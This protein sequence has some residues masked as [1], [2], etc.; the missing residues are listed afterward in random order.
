MN[1]FLRLFVGVALGTGMLAGDLLADDLMPPPWRGL[2][3]SY[4]SEFDRADDISPL[5]KVQEQFGPGGFPP[6]EGDPDGPSGPIQPGEGAQIIGM[7]QFTQPDGQKYDIF[8]PNVVDDLPLKLTQIQITYSVPQG[9]QPGPSR[10]DILNAD[11]FDGGFIDIVD[12]QVFTPSGTN[13]PTVFYEKWAGEIIPNPDWEIFQIQ[14][15][16][17]LD[18]VVVDTI[19]IPEPSTITS[20]LLSALALFGIRRSRAYLSK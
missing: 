9:Q 11:P 15:P 8:Y 16:G 14:V 5:E 12:Q 20:V 3:N 13:D 1:I 10:I 18:Q 19:S 7:M 6:Y 4:F 17:R 2:P